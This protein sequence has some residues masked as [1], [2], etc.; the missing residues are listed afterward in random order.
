MLNSP[1]EP[2]QVEISIFGPGKGES[3]VAHLGDG[4]WMVVDSCLNRK[5]SEPAALEY[6]RLL[7]VDIA[8]KVKMVVATHWHDDH[9]HG[10]AKVLDAAKNARFVDSAAFKRSLLSRVVEYGSQTG[11]N[12]SVTE[13]YSNIHRILRDRI[14]KGE[15]KESVGP[16]Q[17]I[18]NARLLYLS[19]SS[20]TVKAEVIAL[21]PSNGTLNHSDAELE[22]ALKLFKERKRPSRQGPNQLCV[23]LWVK[24]GALQTILG[25]DLEHVSGVTEGW[26]AIVRSNE[27]PEG[28]AAIFK[29]PH[30][31]SKNAHSDA[32]WKELLAGDPIAVVTPYAPSRLPTA[33]DMKRLCEHT[34]ELYLTSDYRHYKASHRDHT[35]EKM[36]RRR[37][38]KLRPLEGSM[39]HV[40][41]RADARDENAK[42]TIELFEGAE[43][44]CA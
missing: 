41:M 32:C 4:D 43:R 3:I 1:P 16:M 22:N 42:P 17:A 38:K 23:V 44:K 7:N 27:R 20:R 24:V 5:T 33:N 35:V 28:A 26:N 36:L 2:H 14:Q 29:V 11:A 25:A 31:G 18:A 6:L 12:A 21:S 37:E 9:I 34:K 10:L 40:R 15:K 39:G 8:N 30:H 13:E 19:D